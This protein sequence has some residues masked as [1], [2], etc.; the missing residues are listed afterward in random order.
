MEREGGRGAAVQERPAQATMAAP[1]TPLDSRRAS[2]YAPVGLRAPFLAMHGAGARVHGAVELY[3]KVVGS[4]RMGDGG[5]GRE[6]WM[7]SPGS[8]FCM[9]GGRVRESH[10]C[11]EGPGLLPN[12]GW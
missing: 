6:R 9:G 5:P 11:T 4:G 1:R 2:M 8:G 10:L 7:R 3:P 12:Q